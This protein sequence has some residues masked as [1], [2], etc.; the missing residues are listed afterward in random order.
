MVDLVGSRSDGA[1]GGGADSPAS[2]K[3]APGPGTGSEH[4]PI[5]VNCRRRECSRL[6]GAARTYTDLQKFLEPRAA[7]ISGHGSMAGR[8]Y[9]AGRVGAQATAQSERTRLWLVA[10]RFQA[11]SQ[12]SMML[13]RLANTELASQ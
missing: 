12:A 5:V 8:T 7:F 11:I 13:A 10:N 6:T 2:I 4:L 1:R 9:G 3:A